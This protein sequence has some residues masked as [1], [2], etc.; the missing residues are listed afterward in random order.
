MPNTSL[1]NGRKHYVNP[2]SMLCDRCERSLNCDW[3]EDRCRY[4]CDACQRDWESEN[5]ADPLAPH[6]TSGELTR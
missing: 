1:P 2:F 3:V 6:I 4:E 5:S